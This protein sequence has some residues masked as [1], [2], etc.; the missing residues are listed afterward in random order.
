MITYK[1]CDLRR[2]EVAENDLSAEALGLR[3]QFL[4]EDKV[5]D[6]I[7]FTESR[8][9]YNSITCA[10]LDLAKRNNT[11]SRTLGALHQCVVQMVGYIRISDSCRL[12]PPSFGCH[13]FLGCRPLPLLRS[14]LGSIGIVAS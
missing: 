2:H 1:V 13:L 4:Q 12:N 11:L 9:C 3:D 5:V 10:E 8:K 7:G 14:G 6:R